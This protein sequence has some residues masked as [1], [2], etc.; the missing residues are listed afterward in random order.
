MPTKI[1]QYN[2]ATGTATFDARPGAEWQNVLVYYTLGAPLAWSNMPAAI[3]FLNGVTNTRPIF[4]I[5]LTNAIEF[6]VLVTLNGVLGATNAKI[7][8][9][10]KAT[11]DSVAANY[12]VLGDASAEIFCGIGSGNGGVVSTMMTGAA[13][14]IVAAARTT[15]FVG[16]FGLDGDGAA[17][18]NIA[19]IIYQYR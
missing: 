14:P 9:R 10:W 6:R 5:D 18:P 8:A 1:Q 19:Q 7:C 4:P 2:A 11:Y 3:T 13:T 17:D 12:A 16:G 15:V